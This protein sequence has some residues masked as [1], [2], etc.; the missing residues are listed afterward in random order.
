MIVSQHGML[1]LNMIGKV[2]R[3]MLI[4]V[5]MLAVMLY[6]YVHVQL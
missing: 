4:S 5:E 2:E 3:I 6:V 1:A